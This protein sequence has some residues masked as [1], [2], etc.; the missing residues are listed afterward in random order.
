M[1][2]IQSLENKFIELTND[3]YATKLDHICVVETWLD[4]NSNNNL[5]I[6]GRTI[7][8]ASYGRGKG[9]SMFSLL[10]RKISGQNAIAKENY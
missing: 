3:L 5:S 7:S 6:P 1:V 10:T 4:H 8:H 2:N 9:C